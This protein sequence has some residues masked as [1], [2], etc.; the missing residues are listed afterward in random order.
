MG[1][2]KRSATKTIFLEAKHYCLW[3]EI[4]KQVAGCDSVEVTNPKTKVSLIK[5]GYSFDKVTGRAVK[6]EKYDTEKKYATRY[7]GFKLHLVDPDGTYVLKMPYQ[8]QFLRRFL[9]VAPNIVWASP[10]SVSVFKGKSSKPGG[11]DELGVWFQQD[12]ATVKPYFTR[13]SPHGMPEAIQDPVSHD[14]DFRAQHRW[15]VQYLWDNV[16]PGIEAAA[17][18]AAPPIEPMPES[19]AAGHEGDEQDEPDTD[20]YAGLGI[21]DDDVPF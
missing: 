2:E 4:K 9:R 11:G 12:S 17:A 19:V 10:F 3:Q 14:W 7:F 20:P 16:I 15:L 21:T 5:Y 1:L 6:L 8:S 18:K 13:E